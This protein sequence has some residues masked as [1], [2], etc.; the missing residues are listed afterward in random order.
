MSATR[1]ACVRKRELHAQPYTRSYA[2]SRLSPR[3]PGPP[4]FT[5]PHPPFLT[6][7]LAAV[8]PTPSSLLTLPV[9]SCCPALSATLTRAISVAAH[10]RVSRVHI[11]AACSYTPTV[12]HSAF[13][14][15]RRPAGL[16]AREPRAGASET[17]RGT[18]RPTDR[19]ERRIKKRVGATE[20]DDV[21]VTGNAESTRRT[22]A[23]ESSGMPR[24][25]ATSASAKSRDVAKENVAFRNLTY[26]RAR[27]R[28]GIC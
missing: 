23:R 2:R 24:A 21:R 7:T 20:S 14:L 12:R 9:D 25:R 1:A 16:R 17:A 27:A 4:F 22:R 8:T 26:F 28:G 10:E 5:P 15:Y 19:R 13:P 6:Y 18:D 11:R 3:T